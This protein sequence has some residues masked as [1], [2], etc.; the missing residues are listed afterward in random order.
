MLYQME[1]TE[2]NSR[3]IE[4]NLPTRLSV[5]THCIELTLGLNYLTFWNGLKLA[6]FPG[7]RLE[8]KKKTFPNCGLKPKY[9]ITKIVYIKLLLRQ[10][11]DIEDFS[12]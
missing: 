9:Y 7:W 2:R 1:E 5:Q 6:L 11:I 4:E 8:Q 10:N 12:S 3:F